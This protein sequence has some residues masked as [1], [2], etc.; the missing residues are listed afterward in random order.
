MATNPVDAVIAASGL[1]NDSALAELWGISRAAVA[2]FK[3]KGYLPLDRAKQAVQDWPSLRLRDLVK[4]EI[5]D[6]MDRA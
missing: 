5:R 6:A 3:R 4:P 2:Q 1:G